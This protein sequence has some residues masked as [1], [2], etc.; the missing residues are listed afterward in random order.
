M[1]IALAILVGV[2]V[3]MSIGTGVF[4]VRGLRRDIAAYFQTE[5]E[6]EHMKMSML[7]DYATSLALVSANRVQNR[8]NDFERRLRPIFVVAT[9]NPNFGKDTATSIVDLPVT[10]PEVPATDF[11]EGLAELIAVRRKVCFDFLYFGAWALF[12]L[13]GAVGAAYGLQS[14]VGGF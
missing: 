2:L 3:S 9:Q 11:A 7:L 6:F 10:E 1:L 12:N 4:L 5:S 14:I 8:I 13:V